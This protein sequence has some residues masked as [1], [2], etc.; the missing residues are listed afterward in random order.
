[1]RVSEMPRTANSLSSSSSAPVRS[2]TTA[3]SDVLSLPVGAGSLPGGLTSTNRVTAPAW[4]AMSSTSG[5]SPYRSAAIGAQTAASNSPAA[6]AAAAA[7]VDVVGSG[8]T[9]GRFAA[10]QP[11][12]CARACG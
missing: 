4:S 7:A 3:T 6:T 5:R 9:P 10:S 8:G 11:A 12:V 1:M 2:P